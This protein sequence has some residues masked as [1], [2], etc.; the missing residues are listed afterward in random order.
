MTR[1]SYYEEIKR[2]A[3]EIRAV[4]GFTTPKVRLSDLRRIYHSEG[5]RIET[6]PPLSSASRRVRLRQLRGAYIDEPPLPP[7][8]M[9]ARWLPPEPRIFTLAHELKHHFRDRNRGVLHCL[10]EVGDDVGEIGAE[11]FAAE[12]IFPD[13]DFSR[14]P[15]GMGIG[16]GRC[17]AEDIVRL[18]HDTETTLSYSSLAKRAGIMG[19]APPCSMVRIRWRALAEKMFGEPLYRRILRD[20]AQSK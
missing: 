9:V 7:W 2:L 15:C 18:K 4:Y 3:R 14:H 1:R 20:R 8:V 13:S 10:R 12:L 17:S 11:I 5:I 16:L 19:F 6:W